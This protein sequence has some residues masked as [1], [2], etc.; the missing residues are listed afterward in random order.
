MFRRV[1]VLSVGLIC[2][3]VPSLAYADDD[4][5]FTTWQ[6]T[7][8]SNVNQS[9]IVGPSNNG[10]TIGIAIDGQNQGD[11]ASP[12]SL[13]GVINESARGPGRASGPPF[14]L[15]PVLPSTGG[16]N[17]IVPGAPTSFE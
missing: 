16:A 4:K 3:A 14:S 11:S 8:P 15:P 1:F 13:G 12:G 9:A 10:L 17:V 5:P 7:T 2:C 6:N